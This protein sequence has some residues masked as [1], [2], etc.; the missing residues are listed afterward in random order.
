MV[1]SGVI[2]AESVLAKSQPR[3]FEGD[4]SRAEKRATKERVKEDAQVS[5]SSSSSSSEAAASSFWLFR[6]G[7]RLLIG[8]YAT[9]GS[10]VAHLARRMLF[11]P[12][13]VSQ[14]PAAIT[15]DNASEK[16]AKEPL[17]SCSQLYAKRPVQR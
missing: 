1:E 7:R 6:L 13:K 5:S 11:S 9:I 14:L 2:R 16:S 12:A 10:I 4:Q 17:Q 8:A 15:S 3:P